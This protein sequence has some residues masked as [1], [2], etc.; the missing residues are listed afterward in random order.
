MSNVIRR[1]LKIIREENAGPDAAS[2]T[3]GLAIF[4]KS[5][6]KPSSLGRFVWKNEI[7]K[8]E[9]LMLWGHQWR[10]DQNH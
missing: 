7:C 9:D 3:E 10:T 2:L 6:T 4:F 1:V 5:D 8:V